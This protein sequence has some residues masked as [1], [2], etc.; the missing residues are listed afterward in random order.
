MKGDYDSSKGKLVFKKPNP[1]IKQAAQQQ[2]E[3]DKKKKKGKFGFLPEIATD[4][5][6]RVTTGKTKEEQGYDE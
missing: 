4:F 3:E 1:A 5:I 6:E 2:H